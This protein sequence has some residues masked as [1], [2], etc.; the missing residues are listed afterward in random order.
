M[1]GIKSFG[2]YLPE[3]N[4]SVGELLPHLNSKQK[5][6]IGVKHSLLEKE[7]TATEMAII[8]SKNAIKK[9]KISP[10]EIDLVISC[11]AGTSDYLA[12]QTSGKI[13]EEIKATNAGFIDVY[14]GCCGFI[15][16][17]RIARNTLV[18]EKNIRNIL[19]CSGEKWENVIEKRIVGGYV[20][21]DGAS[22]TII[23]RENTN[24]LILGFGLT[25]RGDFVNI[26][27]IKAGRINGLDTP[28]PK[29]KYY[30]I[31]NENPKGLEELKKVNLKIYLSTAKK[32]LQD[33]KCSMKDI[34]YIIF[35]NG[36]LDFT[37][38]LLTA[39]NINKE[40]TNYQ[41]IKTTGDLSTAD[42][43]VNYQRMLEDKLIN[44]GQKVLVLSQGAGMSWAA[45]ILQV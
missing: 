35:P 9:A 30:D 12:W 22:A 13:Q 21:S 23:S 1:I 28:N 43:M 31:T 7:F 2:K 5:A 3:N 15:S 26:S 16:S 8:A 20:F 11:Q 34:D 25:G 41:Y 24:N 33:A 17:M 36:R 10:D 45:T 14:Q 27:K 4:I 6:K 32:A 40:K 29:H 42:A 39:F 19:V 18:A 38:K 44:K 37:D